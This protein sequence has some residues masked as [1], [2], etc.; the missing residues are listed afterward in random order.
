MKRILLASV[1]A[2]GLVGT[3]SAA[4]LAVAPVAY[5]PVFTWTGC[6]LGA[7][8]G[9]IS[10]KSTHHSE[11]SPVGTY[12]VPNVKIG[13]WYTEKKG[14]G[15]Q[16]GSILTVLPETVPYSRNGASIDQSGGTFGG[17]FGCQAQLGSW[18]F[19]AEWDWAYTGIKGDSTYHWVAGEN[20]N[21]EPW[22]GYPPFGGD[23][24]Q[25]TH[26]ELNWLSTARLRL[27]FAWDRMLLYATGGLAY[28]GV[29][30]YTHVNIVSNDYAGPEYLIDYAGS[31]HKNRIGYT[32]G[33]GLEWAFANN[34]TAK[35]EFLYVDLGS[36]DYDSPRA[37]QFPCGT[38]YKGGTGG[39]AP[40]CTATWKTHV[41]AEEYVVRVGLNYLF[42]TGGAPVVA[43]Y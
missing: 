23:F 12:P 10:E 7:N 4:D 20:W 13:D 8:G 6:Y 42:H 15:G 34:W 14:G 29:D 36:F 21:F 35:A 3:A 17:Q 11:V 18:V 39:A 25:Y 5:V 43:R 31:Y 40:A 27:G 9:W 32:I 41:E 2:L 22:N 33:G 28:G 38:G 19:G 37:Q 26:K 24:Y 1:A 30:A 16:Y